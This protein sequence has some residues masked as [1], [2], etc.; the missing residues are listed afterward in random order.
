M[1]INLFKVYIVIFFLLSNFMMFAQGDDDGEGGLEGGDAPTA[2]INGK[3]IWLGFAAIV[4]AFYSFKK[5]KK[6]V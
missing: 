4:L 6:I 1:G 2:S 3:L 5:E